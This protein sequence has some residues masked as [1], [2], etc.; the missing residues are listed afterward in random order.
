MRVRARVFEG[1][2]RRGESDAVEVRCGV[3]PGCVDER[4]DIFVIGVVLA[5]VLRLESVLDVRR[6]E[7][8]GG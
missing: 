3:F 1:K 2:R 7:E 6:G 4:G 8:G 5:P